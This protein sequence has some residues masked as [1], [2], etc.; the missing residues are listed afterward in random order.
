VRQGSHKA[1]AI[2]TAFGVGEPAR[3]TMHC[4][5]IC[6]RKRELSYS[7]R[8][9]ANDAIRCFVE[10][11]SVLYIAEAFQLFRAV[12]YFLQNTSREEPTA[13]VIS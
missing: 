11:P 3:G 6:R 4:R 10:V 5:K 1:V 12:A 8:I 13:Y 7:P 9:L 2:D